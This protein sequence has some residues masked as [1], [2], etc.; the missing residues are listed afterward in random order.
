MPKDRGRE[1]LAVLDLKQDGKAVKIDDPQKV[2][3]KKG[4]YTIA[5]R[6]GQTFWGD[7]EKAIAALQKSF[8][9][10]TFTWE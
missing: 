3:L 4:A 7:R 9:E 2:T 6:K 8:T 1:F 10:C 5:M